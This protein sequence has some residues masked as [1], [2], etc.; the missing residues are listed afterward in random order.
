[1]MN[2]PGTVEF[3]FLLFL[4][5]FLSWIKAVFCLAAAVL[6]RNR[7]ISAAAAGLVGIAETAVDMGPQLFF[8]N[9]L[10]IYNDLFLALPVLAAITW[11]G[12]GRALWALWNVATRR[13]A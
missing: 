7:W 12:I 1:M 6:I 2:W 3:T 5:L 11:W 4:A 8:S 10:D 13:R 9:L